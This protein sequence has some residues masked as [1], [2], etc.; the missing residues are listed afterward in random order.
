M[1]RREYREV[2]QQLLYLWH[3]IRCL[4]QHGDLRKCKAGLRNP[5]A[6][7]LCQS[8]QSFEG[9]ELLFEWQWGAFELPLQFGQELAER[10][11]VHL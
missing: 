9:T 4:Q 5:L 2:V 7:A 1:A 10:V 3:A 8:P 6:D 11:S